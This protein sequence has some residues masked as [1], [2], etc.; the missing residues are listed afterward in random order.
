MMSFKWQLRSW[1]YYNYVSFYQSWNIFMA[2]NRKEG[3]N[4]HSVGSKW[5]DQFYWHHQIWFKRSQRVKFRIAV[6]PQ[7]FY[8][9]FFHY[10]NGKELWKWKFFLRDKFIQIYYLASKELDWAIF[11]AKSSFYFQNRKY[12][13]FSLAMCRETILLRTSAS[14]I[15]TRKQSVTLSRLFPEFHWKTARHACGIL[16]RLLKV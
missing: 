5:E 2:F 16:V 11:T 7:A 1:V 15:S 8:C 6:F 14:N 12:F 13:S 10:K 3:E 4:M 9:S